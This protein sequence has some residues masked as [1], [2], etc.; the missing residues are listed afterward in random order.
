[1]AK[2]QDTISIGFEEKIWK[3]ADILRGNLSADMAIGTYFGEIPH[4]T[5]QAIGDPRCP[6][7]PPSDLVSPFARH[8][9]PEAVGTPCDNVGQIG[10]LVELQTL[11]DAKAIA[12]R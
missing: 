1:M 11:H 8:R 12:Q 7:R 2:K 5:Q 3:A 6:S 10:N 9:Q 4:P